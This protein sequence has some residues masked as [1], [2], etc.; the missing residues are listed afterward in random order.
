[1]A[2][3]PSPLARS[4]FSTLLREVDAELPDLELVIEDIA[5]PAQPAALRAGDID[6]GVCHA[7]PLSA[8]EEQSI[9]RS[10][11][12]SDTMNCALLAE[13]SPLARLPEIS[14]RDLAN[15]P[16]LFGD[17]AFQPALYDEVFDIFDQLNFE[18]RVDATYPGLRTVWSLVADGHGWALGF[19][20]QCDAP[21]TGTVAVP[22]EGFSMPW[23]LD[24][25][26]R[27]EESRSLV[28]DVADRLRQI[29]KSI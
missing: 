11:L 18:P 14:L 17:R 27:A 7:S 21:P 29:A 8:V 15:V 1:M 16:F 20:S 22:L 6:L 9:D 19:A 28:L 24:L 26:T 4:L 12:A 2:G 25:L 10:R 5:T 3:V 13:T 23:G